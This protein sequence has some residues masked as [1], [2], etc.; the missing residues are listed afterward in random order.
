[1]CVLQAM[2]S[3]DQYLWGCADALLSVFLLS[4]SIL[5]AS[6]E[7]AQEGAKRMSA[8]KAALQQEV[9]RMAQVSSSNWLLQRLSPLTHLCSPLATLVMVFNDLLL[10]QQAL[11]RE[12]RLSALPLEIPR[13]CPCPAVALLG[14]VV[15]S[16][17]VKHSQHAQ[18]Q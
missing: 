13:Q 2:G 4:F 12:A 16:L 3:M 7:I 5:Q 9:Q 6:L 18:A 14:T 11:A 1:M 15:D 10:L 8:T 17:K